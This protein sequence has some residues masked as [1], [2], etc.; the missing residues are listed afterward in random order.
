MDDLLPADPRARRMALIVLAIGA[1]L[2]TVAIWW[3]SSY[4]DQLTVLARTDRDASLR[5]FRT[6]ILPVVIVVVLGAVLSGAV[7]MR[8]GARIIRSA[9]FPPEGSKLVRPSR[10]HVGAP[11]RAIGFAVAFAGFLVAAGSLA[12]M[13]II[14]WFLQQADAELPDAAAAAVALAIVN[15]VSADRTDHPR[16]SVR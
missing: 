14:L 10:Q 2:G 12:F 13:A 11:A 5:L 3:L 8:Q 6:R 7:M 15:V 9:R 16:E 4:I 1:V